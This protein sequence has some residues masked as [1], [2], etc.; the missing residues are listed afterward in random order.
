MGFHEITHIC[1]KFFPESCITSKSRNV[2][3][4]WILWVLDVIESVSDHKDRFPWYPDGFYTMV[5]ISKKVPTHIMVHVKYFRETL[6][7]FI[8]V[9][10]T[11]I[12]VT[13]EY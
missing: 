11:Q 4:I 9:T 2:L 6:C 5:T 13:A 12:E 8:Q 7:S 3:W 1:N 10:K